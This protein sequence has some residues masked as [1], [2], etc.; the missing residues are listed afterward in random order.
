MA[1]IYDIAKEVGVSPATVSRV[2]NGRVGVKEETVLR[3]RR[4]MEASSFQPRWK[5]IDRNRLLVLLPE[6]RGALED[7]YTSRI[8][9][10]ICDTAFTSGFGLQLRP[11]APQIRN[12]R[13]LRQMIMAEGVCGCVII[14][15]FQGYSLAERLGLAQFPHA[16]VGYKTQDDGAH[17]ILL[18]DHAAGANAAN[19]LMS[20]GHKKIAM[21]SFKHLDHGHAQR[22][23]GYAE[24]LKA[25]KGMAAP[26]CIEFETTST[27]NGRSAARR[28]LSL[29]DRPS[30]VIVTNEDLAAGFQQEARDMG[31]RIPHDLSIIGFEETEKLAFLDTPM[32]AMRIPAHSMGIEATK[33][34][35]S[36][37]GD[38]DAAQR[39]PEPVQTVHTPISLIVRRS[40]ATPSA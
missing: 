26:N 34:V 25:R 16:I 39:K 12:N 40:T 38:T 22:Y 37:L 7:G 32:T 17:Q 28:L 14:T 10:G 19:Y 23:A 21:V 31:L 35:F 9:S 3:I 27:E 36:M 18:D 24:A 2:I 15:M 29:P 11:F 6:H 8:L 30:A 5:A 1:T 13:E 4:A 20:L 33:M